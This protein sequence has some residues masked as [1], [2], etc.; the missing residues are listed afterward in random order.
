MHF[1]PRHE[2]GTKRINIPVV[3]AVNDE[4]SGVVPVRVSARSMQHV[5]AYA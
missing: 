2:C 3:Y 5:V 1:T 4:H